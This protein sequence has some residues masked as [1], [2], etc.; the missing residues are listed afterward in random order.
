MVETKSVS[1]FAG[2]LRRP[3]EVCADAPGFPE[4]GLTQRFVRG[5]ERANRQAAGLRDGR[6]QAATPHRLVAGVSSPFALQQDR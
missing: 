2:E 1:G 3:R 4:I 6:F 5:W